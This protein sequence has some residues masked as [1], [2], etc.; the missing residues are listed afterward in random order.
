ML[1][2][3]H[4]MGVVIAALFIAATYIGADGMSRALNVSSYIAD[5]IVALSLLTILV[6][7]FLVSYR[8]RR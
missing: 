5:V 8:V 3:L 6:S 4:P 7:M 1:A 2:G